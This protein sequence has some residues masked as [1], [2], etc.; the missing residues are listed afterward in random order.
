M[1]ERA[2]IFPPFLFVCVT[3]ANL[4]PAESGPGIENDFHFQYALRAKDLQ[5]QW[6]GCWAKVSQENLIPVYLDGIA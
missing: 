2:G 4:L 5:I 6:V 1:I 3:P